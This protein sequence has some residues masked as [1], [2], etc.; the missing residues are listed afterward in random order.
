MRRPA[1][2]SRTLNPLQL[3]DQSLIAGLL[4]EDEHRS[5]KARLGL[6]RAGGAVD[7]TLELPELPRTTSKPDWQTV[8]QHADYA[9]ALKSV[10]QFEVHGRY[11][12]AIH[13]GKPGDRR[14]QCNE[15]VDCPHHLR[16]K[17]AREGNHLVQSDSA[18]FHASEPKAK[19]RQNAVL[20]YDQEE[21]GEALM[22]RGL[23]HAMCMI[24]R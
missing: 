21:H 7:A 22:Q 11:K 24:L 13:T 8:G 6:L 4:T 10:K 18:A 23:A 5:K 17:R 2:Q 15:H 16:I 12:W 9:D 14:F 20:A 3:L 19:R 1:G